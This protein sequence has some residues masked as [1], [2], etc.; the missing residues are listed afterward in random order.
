[1]KVEKIGRIFDP[2]DHS[3]PD[4]CVSFAQAPQALQIDDGVRVYFSTRSIDSIGGKFR[5]RIAFVD[6]SCDFKRILR[7]SSRSVVPLGGLGCFDEHGVFPM[8]VIRNGREIWGYTCGWNRRVSVSVDTAIGLAISTDGGETFV[9][10]GDGPILGPSLREPFLVGDGFVLRASDVFHMWYIFGTRWSRE[11]AGRAP[12][13]VYKIG[14]ATSED[15]KSWVKQDGVQIVESILGP[16]ECQ[17]LPSV[18]AFGG[19]YHMVF[20]F[21]DIHGFRTDPAR[22]YRI[23]YA[24]S[25]D[26]KIWT[27]D[28]ALL[29]LKGTEGAW[30]SHMQCYPNLSVLNEAL[31]LLYNG[32][33]FGRDGFGLARITM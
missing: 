18:A 25:T 26:L 13:R 15:G 19:R 6:M 14:H 33:A 8:S 17:A 23:G 30:D 9:R 12:D 20:C 3:F 11:T 28:D 21:R 4:G 5:S 24:W 10:Q 2:H 16:D 31:H 29:G 1:M 27:R 32:N 7:V 22:G